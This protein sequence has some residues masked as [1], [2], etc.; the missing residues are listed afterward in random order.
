MAE[1]A[2]KRRDLL[3]QPNYA[4]TCGATPSP[5]LDVQKTGEIPARLMG[6]GAAVDELD[7][8][9]QHLT[10]RSA[11][12]LLPTDKANCPPLDVVKDESASELGQCLDGLLLRVLR[13]KCSVDQLSRRLAI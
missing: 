7:K 8:A 5:A 9:I 13:A 3:R 4:D 11:V 6:I 1:P 12:L 10:D 2:K